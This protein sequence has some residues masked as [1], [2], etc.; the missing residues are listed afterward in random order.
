M[1]WLTWLFFFLKK[2]KIPLYCSPS[3]G[4]LLSNRRVPKSKID[5]FSHLSTWYY[6]WSRCIMRGKDSQANWPLGLA[7]NS[8]SCLAHSCSRVYSPPPSLLFPSCDGRRLR[9][10][11]AQLKS[12]F[13]SS[14]S[15]PY[16]EA[17]FSLLLL[18]EKV[19]C[20]MGRGGEGRGGG[21]GL[22]KGEEQKRSERDALQCRSF[23]ACLKKN[24]SRTRTQRFPKSLMAKKQT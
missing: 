13:S 22:R 17:S 14:S 1:C 18:T 21:G 20:V 4:P 23:V 19:C 24:Y 12:I 8:E 3:L 10:G 6:T 11:F 2:K 7:R 16:L 5:F 15:S 9:V